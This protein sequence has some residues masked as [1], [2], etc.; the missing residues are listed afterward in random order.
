MSLIN[1]NY[2]EPVTGYTILEFEKK[3]VPVDICY[4][5]DKWCPVVESNLYYLRQ[6]NQVIYMELKVSNGTLVPCVYVREN[7][8]GRLGCVCRK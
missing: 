8:P 6:R 2:V 4:D 3:T 7:N 1:L 5:C